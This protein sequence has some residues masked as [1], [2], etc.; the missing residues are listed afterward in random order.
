MCAVAAQPRTGLTPTIPTPQPRFRHWLET[1]RLIAE[2]DGDAVRCPLAIDD[3]NL[4]DA[5]VDAVRR[6]STRILE[7]EGVLVDTPQCSLEVGHDLLRPNQ[8]DDL[9]DAGYV[10][11]ELA[12]THGRGDQRPGLGDGVDTA[13]HD[14]GRGAEPADLVGLRRTVHAEDPWSERLVPTGPLD[15]IGDARRVERLRRPLMHLRPRRDE[16]QDDPFGFRAVPGA[17]DGDPVGF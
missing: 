1:Q 6:L 8:K 2:D 11:A 12:A 5:T 4:V 9:P 10:R 3:E 17:Q 7:G 15:L 16:I 13:E 14:V